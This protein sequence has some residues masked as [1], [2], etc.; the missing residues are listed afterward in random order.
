MPSPSVSV[1][2]VPRLSCTAVALR[3]PALSM[4]A[5]DPCMHVARM[6]EKCTL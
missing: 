3:N 2:V 4:H 1:Q 5:C 6:L